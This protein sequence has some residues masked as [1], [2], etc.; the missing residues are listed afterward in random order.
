MTKICDFDMTGMTKDHR[1]LTMREIKDLIEDK[2]IQNREQWRSGEPEAT[3]I[4]PIELQPNYRVMEHFT[5]KE[6]RPDCSHQR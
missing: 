1:S 5:G 6:R 3:N 2:T 4:K